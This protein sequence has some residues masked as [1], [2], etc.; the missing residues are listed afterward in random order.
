[1]KYGLRLAVLSCLVLSVGC[2]DQ[3]PA[4]IELD[5]AVDSFIPPLLD[6]SVIDEDAA[7]A[8]LLGAFMDSCQSNDDCESG[9]CIA[10]DDGRSICT[11]LCLRRQDCPGD[12]ECRL[13]DNTPPDIV[14]ACMPRGDRL[15]GVCERDSDCP[16]GF[17]FE[18]DGESICGSDC[19]ADTDC[20]EDFVCDNINDRNTCLPKTRSCSCNVD[21]AGEVR[22]CES[23][24]AHGTCIGRETCDLE[25][26][27]SGCTAS[28]PAPE[29]CNQVDDDCNGFTDDIPGLG[30]VCERDAEIDGQTIS[31]SGRL[32]CTGENDAPVCT[33]TEPTGELCNFIDDDCDGETDEGFDGR[34]D[35]CLVGIGTCQRVGVNECSEDGSEIACSVAAGLPDEELCDGL[36]NDCD[37]AQDEVFEG[38]NGVCYAGEGAC[39]AAGALR[40]SADLMDMTCSAVARDPGPET[41]NGIDDDCDGTSDESFEAL[42]APCSDGV[43]SCRRQGFRTCSEDGLEVVCSA[44]AVEPSE[45]TCNGL[46]DDCDATTDEGFVDVNTA[47]SVG[48]GACRRS[49]VNQCTA[50]GASVTCGA[51]AGE[52]SDELCNGL[53]DDCDGRTDE[54][55]DDLNQACSVGLG[56]CRVFG[57]TECADEGDAVVCPVEPAQAAPESCNELDDDCDGQTDE[58]YPGIGETCSAGVGS[59]L[60]RGI[61]TCSEN[62]LGLACSARPEQ[63]SEEICNG[64]DD[65]CDGRT[66]EGFAGLNTA[67]SRG[68]GT[69][70]RAGI[71]RCSE[72]GQSVV[73]GAVE[74]APNDDICN[75]LDDDCDGQTDEGF[76]QL[77]TACSVGVGTCQRSGINQCSEDG[78]QV[79]CNAVE[80]A[81]NNDICNGLDDDCD[82]RT[83]EGFVGLNTACSV[84][85]G[86]CRRAGINRCAED[87]REVACSAVAGVPIDEA[88][89]GLDDDCD[90]DIDE[91]FADIGQVCTVGLGRCLRAGVQLCTADGIGSE[92][93]V[94]PG[95]PTNESCNGLDDDCDGQT[96]ETHPNLGQVCERGTGLCRRSGVLVCDADP[97]APV[98]CDAVPGEAALEDSCNY[99][100]DDCDGA[101]DEDF[102]DDGG[103]YSTRAHCGACGSDCNALWGEDPAAFGVNPVCERLAGVAQC[104][105]TCLDGFFD[106]DGLSANGCEFRPDAEAIYVSP[107]ENGGLDEDNCGDFQSPCATIAVGLDRARADNFERVRVSEGVYR[108]SVRLTNGLELLGGHQRDTWVRNPVLFPSIITGDGSEEDGHIFAVEIRDIDQPTVLDGFV[109]N[110][111]SQFQSNGNAYGI[112]IVDATADLLVQNNRIAAGNGG[113]GDDG[114]SGDSG[115]AGTAGGVGLQARNQPTPNP[116]L[117]VSL[118]DGAPGGARVCAGVNVAG[119]R[120]GNAGCPQQNRREGTGISGSGANGGTGGLGGGGMRTLF[121]FDLSCEVSVGIPID[122]TPGNDGGNGFDGTGAQGAGDANGLAGLHWRGSAGADGQ[123]GQPGSG[124]GG[125]GAAAGVDAPSVGLSDIG[126]SGGGGGSAG[127][128]GIGG[129]GGLSGGGSFGLYITYS[130]RIVSAE[131]DLPTVRDNV[132]ARGLGGPGGRGGNGGGGGEGG[133]GGAGGAR[134]A[135]DIMVRDFC[136][137]QAAKGGNGGRGG[138]GGGGGGGQGGI[139]YDIYVVGARGFR[140]AYEQDNDFNI[141]AN[142][143]TGGPAGAGGN[144]SN[145]NIGR[146]TGAVE[147]LSGRILFIQ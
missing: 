145:T 73:C 98:V 140:L 59:C 135:P 75:G 33:A 142:Q 114:V 55:F 56:S 26:G 60:R 85:I 27:W 109:I 1:M 41:C 105:Y 144:S 141:G 93:S 64:V 129:G 147:G 86:T 112:Y 3:Q 25:L 124:G 51:R 132:I 28:E 11:R 123:T 116:C 16:N 31:C 128:P 70:R 38:L 53:D 18:L 99:Q 32:I 91:T 68:T 49:G 146:G 137:F 4:S 69:C 106:T 97:N 120:G 46:D 17:C 20:P 52:P 96:D 134:G 94:D 19:E 66:D 113:R 13:I 74:G 76:A 48:I 43:G 87:G 45:E 108:E 39:R 80:G 133:P 47:C 107:P 101:S 136:S 115:A 44:V 63:P 71:N 81:A 139:S 131:N 95:Q 29:T 2:D 15:C 92:C 10:L 36:D 77:N 143:A 57:V 104:G 78:S 84:G 117:P 122:A 82:G 125:G 23:A 5:M 65:D 24:N 35:V 83:D 58:D 111:E 100:D 118:N 6:R 37:G 61:Q 42:F 62:G 119:G 7:D 67:C 34:G 127:C 30:D 90:G 102:V 40:C 110:G 8:R 50:D 14:S 54:T 79:V 21:V 9:W 126:A 130:N 121:P 22:I 12:W 72:D 138:H 88:C 89:N 103:V